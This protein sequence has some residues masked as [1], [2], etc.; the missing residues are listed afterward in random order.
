MS[1]IDSNIPAVAPAA[2][3]Q[4]HP[5]AIHRLL[6]RPVLSADLDAHA[7]LVAHASGAGRVESI[8]LLLFK[9]GQEAAALPTKHLRRATQ[10]AR[11]SPLPHLVGG[12]LRGICNICADL[13]RLLGLPAREVGAQTGGASD[14]RRMVV[15]GPADNAWA[16]EVDA[17]FG[18][19]SVDQSAL[20][21]PP[22]TV[23]HSVADFTL[24]VTDVGERCV[25]ILDTERILAGFKAGLP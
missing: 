9:I 22:V 23:E 25:T 13:H 12:V 10:V 14:S 1:D 15:V 20:R 5:D 3:S 2:P 21:K 11:P 7:E 8:R 19:E 6:D 17:L 24:A 18:V 4:A 16:F